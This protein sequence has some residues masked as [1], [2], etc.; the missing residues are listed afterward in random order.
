MRFQFK[1]RLVKIVQR[2]KLGFCPRRKSDFCVQLQILDSNQLLELLPKPYHDLVVCNKNLLDVRLPHQ[3][4]WWWLHKS[5]NLLGKQVLVNAIGWL[6]QN[7]DGYEYGWYLRMEHMEI[8]RKHFVKAQAEPEKIQPCF[9]SRSH[10]SQTHQVQTKIGP[11]PTSSVEK[12]FQSPSF[13]RW[14]ATKS[15][16]FL[17]PKFRVNRR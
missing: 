6:V 3:D 4:T 16:K 14:G 1:G 17:V 5:K 11:P 13:V 12:H 9:Y 10:V 7:E 8:Q 2:E 15:Q